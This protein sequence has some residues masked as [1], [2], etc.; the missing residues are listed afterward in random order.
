LSN[1]S[2]YI[3]AERVASYLLQNPHLLDE[4]IRF[5]ET[6]ASP[7][8]SREEKARMLKKVLHPQRALVISMRKLAVAASVI[9]LITLTILW[10]N[11]PQK[12]ATTHTEI[13]VV[14]KFSKIKNNTTSLMKMT[15]PDGSTVQLKP[16]AEI[17]YDSVFEDNRD[18]FLNS[19]EA[20]FDVQKNP[21]VPF[22]VFAKGIKTTALGTSFW[23]ESPVLKPTVLVRL[24][25]GKVELTSTDSAFK[26][27]KVSLLPGF[28]CFIN[29]STG[30]VKITNE[31][32]PATTEV[33]QPAKTDTQNNKAI[34]YTNDG[35]QFKQAALKNVLSQLAARYNV[36][37]IAEDSVTKDIVFTGKLYAT[38][39]LQPIL[40]SICDMNKLSYTMRADSIFLQKK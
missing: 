23:V 4:L 28:S 14:S 25:T 32:Q 10:F 31:K 17:T 8:V 18:V 7:V 21:K 5:D 16:L 36:K 27:K 38:D 33:K 37:I 2:D 35:M 20:W 1:E 24:Q 19:G 13:A 9:G 11:R 3:E 39:S 40:K 6:E 26:M 15:L 12:I 34:L 29:K 30:E 22:N